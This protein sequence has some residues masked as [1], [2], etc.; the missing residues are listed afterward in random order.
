MPRRQCFALSTILAST[1]ST[2]V[3]WKTP[4][5][6]S[7]ERRLI[8]GILK[9]LLY[10]ARSQKLIEAGSRNTAPNRRFV[11]RDILQRRQQKNERVT[12]VLIHNFHQNRKRR[13]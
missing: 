12:E 3:I 1:L 11:S 9:P 8:A 13:P 5:G 7:P 10:V 2:V 6:N 4:G